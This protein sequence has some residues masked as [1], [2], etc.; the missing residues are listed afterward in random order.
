MTHPVKH[1]S[2]YPV[3]ARVSALTGDSAADLGQV[4]ERRVSLLHHTDG[5]ERSPPGTS[6]E[7][8]QKKAEPFTRRTP[9]RRALLSWRLWWSTTVWELCSAPQPGWDYGLRVY[10]IVP[11]DSQVIRYVQMNDATT[12]AELF[13]ERKA[14]PFDRDPENRTLLWVSLFSRRVRTRLT[15]ASMPL[16]TRTH[17]S[18]FLGSYFNA[19]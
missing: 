1:N 17:R 18:T 10:N 12:V 14:S 2:A 15:I 6:C 8:K 16:V 3:P 5:S 13:R 4:T 19:A 9:Q 7:S 11:E